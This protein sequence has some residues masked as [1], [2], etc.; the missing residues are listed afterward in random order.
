MSRIVI[1]G[2]GVV[3]LFTAWYLKKEGAEVTVIDRGNLTNGCSFGNA[4][5]IVP[6]HIVPLASPGMLKKGLKNLFRRSSPVAARI[7]PD[8]DLL[9]WY[10][11]FTGA[12][13]TKH[14][15]ESAPVLKELSLFSKHLYAKLKDSG[16]LSFPLW[17]HGLLMLYKSHRTGGELLEEA[18]FAR[19]AGLTVES[20]S[21]ADVHRLEP[22]SMPSVSGGV[23]YLA[24][25]HLNPAALM[26]ALVSALEAS[27]VTLV[28]NCRI[29]KIRLSGSK[30]VAVETERGNFD[31]DQLVITA[32]IWSREI[33]EQ[34]KTHLAVQPGKGYSFKLETKAAINY[35]ALLAD[36]NVAVT[37]L[38]GGITQFG[39]GMELGYG[40]MAVKRA[41]VQ[42][43][44]RAVGEFYPSERAVFVP[45]AQ[46][47]QG[48]RPCSFD[49]LPFIG[50][51]P[52]Y[53]NVFVGTGHSMMG[54][55]LAPATGKLICELMGGQRN[56][57]DLYP[58]RVNR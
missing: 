22:E 33:L 58:F 1:V 40:G 6:S 48:H 14:V 8:A 18:E 34:L 5:L 10:L 42:Q 25:D 45:E 35:P 23:H 47:W 36:A 52:A 43:I 11:K 4:G 17:H 37:P 50:K 20:L 39:G 31:F 28:R 57:I 54:V 19:Q 24:D 7:A 26:Q 53:P 38:G 21:A 49:G 27:G 44:I 15:R 51:V 32:G 13:T 55:T 3:G 12:A 29:D 46:I 9:R 30:A 2:G 41:R 16:E 56:T